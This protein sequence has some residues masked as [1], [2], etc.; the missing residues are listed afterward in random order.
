MN[1]TQAESMAWP[2]SLLVLSTGYTIILV[3]VLVLVEIEIEIE[4]IVMLLLM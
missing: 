2:R 3:L 4:I 1:A